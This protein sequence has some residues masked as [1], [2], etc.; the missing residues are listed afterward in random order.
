MNVRAVLPWCD[1]TGDG[2][3]CQGFMMSTAYHL[4]CLD[5]LGGSRAYKQF[6]S[7]QIPLALAPGVGEAIVAFRNSPA[8]TFLTEEADNTPWDGGSI[9]DWLVKHAGHQLCAE[10]EYG[11]KWTAEREELHP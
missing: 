10:D 9:A 11:G 5:C 1:N 6:W 3:F 2:R 8:G 4:Y 7:Y